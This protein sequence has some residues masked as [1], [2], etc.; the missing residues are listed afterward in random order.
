MFLKKKK[1]NKPKKPAKHRSSLTAPLFNLKGPILS[2]THHKPETAHLLKSVSC[3][4][5]EDYDAFA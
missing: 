1:K 4:V 3:D 5:P 2:L